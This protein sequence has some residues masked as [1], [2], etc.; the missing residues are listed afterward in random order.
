MT[1]HHHEVVVDSSIGNSKTL[2]FRIGTKYLYF[3]Y[4]EHRE[5]KGKP[6]TGGSPA[7]AL[8]PSWHESVS[9]KPPLPK[10]TCHIDDDESYLR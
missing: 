7:V 5:A 3:S 10:H 1:V 6:R 4:P 8:T 2:E 9:A